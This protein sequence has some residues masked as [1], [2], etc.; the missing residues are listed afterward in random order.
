VGRWAIDE[1]WLETKF[2]APRVGVIPELPNKTG[3]NHHHQKR[4]DAVIIGEFHQFL[5][6]KT[7]ETPVTHQKLELSIRN[8]TLV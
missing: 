1:S 5:A 7:L 6:P 3:E 8:E 2:F 4:L